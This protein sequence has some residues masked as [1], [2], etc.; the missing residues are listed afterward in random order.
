MRLENAMR[1]FL[2]LAGWW[3]DNCKPECLL[4]RPFPLLV[5]GLS[6]PL[7]ITRKLFH[8]NR[9]AISSAAVEAACL[10]AERRRVS[11]RSRQSCCSGSGS[12]DGI[13]IGAL[14]LGEQ[15]LS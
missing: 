7:P 6:S 11:D 12:T 13:G 3:L 4:A 5:L 8:R 14:L 1:V 9:L 2:F 15:L 10:Q